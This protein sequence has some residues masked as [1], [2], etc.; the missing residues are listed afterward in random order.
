MAAFEE[1][2]KEGDEDFVEL[3]EEIRT[4]DDLVV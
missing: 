2:A 3:L 4:R 1:R